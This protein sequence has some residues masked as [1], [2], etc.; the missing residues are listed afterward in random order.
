M[1]DGR[2]RPLA[3]A[4]GPTVRFGLCRAL[5]GTPAVLGS[6]LLLLI[7]SA[8]SGQWAGLVLLGCTA[9]GAVTLTRPGERI[10]VRAACRF[11]IPSPA[12]AAALQPPWAAALRMS[13]TAAIDV[14]LYVQHDRRPNA[15]AAG[16]RSVAVTSR[17][18]E[19]YRA[20]RLPEH[21]M[22]AVMV[23]ELGHHATRATRPVLLMAWL[24][25][26]WRLAARLLTG[27]GLTLAGPQTRHGLV[28]VV[29]AG[30]TVAVARALHQGQ[31]LV[32]GVLLAV[33]LA[34]VI[35]PLADAAVSRR[36]EFAA[37]RF[38]ADHGLA[39]E[40]AAALSSLDDGR[41]TASGW[42]WRL[43]AS[44]PMPDRRISVLLAAADA[45]PVRRPV[46]GGAAF[47]ALPGAP[48][49]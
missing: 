17:V 20:G 2:S 41:C 47:T 35:C 11:R 42:L 24:T 26:P 44:H 39:L 36:A 31:L 5:L 13:G 12:Q 16:G 49:G 25:M 3:G 23:H 38:A 9:C 19:D 21:H 7:A 15:Y 46:S 1:A 34:A 29:F 18:V 30:T 33:G 22:V 28:M 45:S 10:A 43:L 6:L 32:G 8:A 40:L 4:R 14:D 48:D 37:D 27:L